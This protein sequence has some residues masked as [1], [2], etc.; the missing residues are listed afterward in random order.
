[1]H[2]LK[3]GLLQEGN[4]KWKERRPVIWNCKD[5]DE[6]EPE[7]HLTSICVKRAVATS[8][9]MPLQFCPIVTINTITPIPNMFTWAPVQQN[10]MVED[11]TVLH[12][13]P[14][15]GDEILEKDGKFIE[16]LIKNYDGKVHGDREN[17]F[18]DDEVY[19][20]LAKALQATEEAFKAAKSSKGSST[21]A[22]L[23]K[24]E[25][26]LHSDT[27]GSSSVDKKE[28]EGMIITVDKSK[29]KARLPS[30]S[31]FRAISDIYPEKGSPA[32]LKER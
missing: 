28:P 32:Q 8:S 23:S 2:S 15:M 31:V 24:K 14:Y 7:S 17:S 30:M 21:T 26:A 22:A 1:L 6:E 18:I 10:M 19:V 20:E 11:E 27:K 5:I 25:A 12:N 9:D 13:I 4:Q 16:E 3:P 29:G